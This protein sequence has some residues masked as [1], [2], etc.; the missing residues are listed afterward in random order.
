[1]KY[2]KLY[3]NIKK[4]PQIGNYVIAKSFCNNQEIKDFVSSN[5]GK[6]FYIDYESEETYIQYENIPIELSTHFN[7]KPPNWSKYKT[8]NYSKYNDF[9][10]NIRLFSTKSVLYFSENKIDCEL[11]LSTKKYNL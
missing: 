4:E 8:K 11:L 7:E 5:V 2:I 1:M 10:S 3:E 9:F 6:I